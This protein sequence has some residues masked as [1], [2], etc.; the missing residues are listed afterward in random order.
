MS[1]IFKLKIQL[2][3][4][5]YIL[6]FD[7]CAS[8]TTWKSKSEFKFPVFLDECGCLKKHG[9]QTLAHFLFPFSSLS[10]LHP[11]LEQTLRTSIHSPIHNV[12]VLPLTYKA[13][14]T[15]PYL[16]QEMPLGHCRGLNVQSC[17]IT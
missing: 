5:K 14:F 15:S 4:L 6:N 2:P 17:R 3:S 12:Q 7:K 13:L 10:W 16:P 8:I 9:S 11:R 1:K